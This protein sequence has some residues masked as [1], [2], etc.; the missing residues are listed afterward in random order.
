[1]VCISNT[2]L[3]NSHDS[4]MIDTH[5]HADTNNIKIE[6]K[7]TQIDTIKTT[8]SNANR[9]LMK[10]DKSIV[11]G[12]LAVLVAFIGI[13]VP[14]IYRK[15]FRRPELTVEI[16]SNSSSSSEVGISPNNDLSKLPLDA[17]NT[18]Y[19]YLFTWRYK[20]IIRNNSETTAFYP[21]ILHPINGI[22]FSKV[23]ELNILEPIRHTDQATIINCE[24]YKHFESIPAKR[25][26][27]KKFP[28]EFE[29]LRILL[30]YKNSAKT[31][32]YTI[33]SFNQYINNN[34]FVRRKP[35]GF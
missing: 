27:I 21:R 17:R 20:L 10:S 8:E 30:E 7:E 34:E 12:I 6:E 2:V 33:F 24:Y 29:S 4:I 22:W 15:Y 5:N 32:F 28:N 14:W 1:M 19:R 35:K 31:K 25:P 11:I 26:R 23:E 13:I 3:L 9:E 18:L 16:V